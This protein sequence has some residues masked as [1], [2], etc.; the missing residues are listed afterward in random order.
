MQTPIQ[1]QSEFFRSEAGL[2]V[3]YKHWKAVHL[4][5]ATWSL[6]TALIPI[7]G[8]FNGLPSS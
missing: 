4:P 6:P 8:I 7:V 1:L 3:A 2:K 5:K